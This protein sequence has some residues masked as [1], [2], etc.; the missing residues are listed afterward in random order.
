LFTDGK[1]PRDADLTEAA[2]LAAQNSKASEQERAEVDYTRVKN[3]RKPSGAKPGFVI[4]E[5][6]NTAVVCPKNS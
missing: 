1:E 6:Y 5:G 2:V 4:Y 3:V